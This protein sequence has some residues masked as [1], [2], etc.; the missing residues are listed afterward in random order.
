MKNWF[1][2][3]PPHEDIRNGHFDEAVFAADLGDVAA[4][5]A[6]PDYRDPYLFYKKTYLT[7]GLRRLLTRVNQKLVQGQGG[8]V[9]EIQ[10]PFGGGKTHALVAIYH[11]LRHG[12]QIRELLPPGL[13]PTLA[14]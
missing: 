5:T 1:D 7:E 9:I 10:T 13:T 2:I 14:F 6:P 4:G 12:E 3:I 11:Y 8:S